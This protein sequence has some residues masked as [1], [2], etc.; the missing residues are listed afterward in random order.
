MLGEQESILWFKTLITLGL[1]ISSM[2]SLQ[3]DKM[4]AESTNRFKTTNSKAKILR[5]KVSV[6]N[7]SIS[8]FLASNSNRIPCKETAKPQPSGG[9]KIDILEKDLLSKHLLATVLQGTST[10]WFGW[11]VQTSRLLC[12]Q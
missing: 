3:Q 9:W 11:F 6:G 1:G 2:K 5:W 12:F 4:E 8:C 10:T 7:R